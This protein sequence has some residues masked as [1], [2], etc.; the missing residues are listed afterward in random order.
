MNAIMYLKRENLFEDN[1]Y[2]DDFMTLGKEDM[3]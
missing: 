1:Q 3:S 2:W